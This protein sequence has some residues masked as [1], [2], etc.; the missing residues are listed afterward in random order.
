MANK[1]LQKI[2]GVEHTLS[3]YAVRSLIWKVVVC[4][5]RTKSA[6]RIILLLPSFSQSEPASSDEELEVRGIVNRYYEQIKKLRC[7]GDL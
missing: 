4:F 2:N 1:S 6:F 5:N 3:M 7:K